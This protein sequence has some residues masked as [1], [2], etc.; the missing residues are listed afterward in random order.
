VTGPAATPLAVEAAVAPAAVTAPDVE[1]AKETT[2][3][4]KK[5]KAL[6]KRLRQIDDLEAKAATGSTLNSDQQSKVSARSEIESE[7]QRW[8]TLG[9]VDVPKK[10]KGLRKK[11]RQIE[12]LEEKL[13]SGVALNTEQKGKVEAKAK[14]VNEIELLEALSLS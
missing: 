5:L 2:E 6:R 9:E 4:E 13:Q 12:E 14:L 10:I 11:M 8:E 3:L 1:G 7:I